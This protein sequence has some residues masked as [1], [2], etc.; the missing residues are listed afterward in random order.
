MNSEPFHASK[1]KMDEFVPEF[2]FSLSFLQERHLQ[3]L[4]PSRIPGTGSVTAST[5]RLLRERSVWGLAFPP[6]PFR[7]QD[8]PAHLGTPSRDPAPP[9]C[10][11]RLAGGTAP[12]ATSQRCPN[13]WLRSPGVS[14]EARGPPQLG[15]RVQLPQA[16]GDRSSGPAPT[17]GQVA[18]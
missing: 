18:P 5:D 1:W 2:T 14:R 13:C 12:L 10:H 15:R 17:P 7:T 4:K 16:Q 8:V 11:G 3:T 9:P 6:R